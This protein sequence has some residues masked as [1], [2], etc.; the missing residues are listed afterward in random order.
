MQKFSNTRCFRVGEDP[1]TSSFPKP[2]L[3]ATRTLQVRYH[4]YHQML[5]KTFTKLPHSKKPYKEYRRQ[6]IMKQELHPDAS[7]APP[8]ILLPN[9]IITKKFIKTKINTETPPPT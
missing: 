7:E 4:N 2:Q 3:R 1:G 6:N 9:S 5:R 8:V